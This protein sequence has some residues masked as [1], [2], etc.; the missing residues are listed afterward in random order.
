[1]TQELGIARL[2]RRDRWVVGACLALACLL[3]WAWLLT[4]ARQMSAVAGM[5]GMGNMGPAPGSWVYFAGAFTMWLLMMVAMMLPS[6]S[7]M[8]LLYARMAGRGGLPPAAVFAGVYMGLWAVFSLLAAG[9]QALLVGEGLVSAATLRIGDG[10]IAG[11]L[12]ILAGLYQLTPLK[13]ACLGACRSPFSFLT[14]LWQPGLGG[15]LRLGLRHGLYCLGC[16]W[17]LMALLFVGGVMSLPWVALL[18]VIVLIE[19]LAPI[20]ETGGKILGAL[21]ASVGLALIVDPALLTA[22]G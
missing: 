20:G 2:L 13:Q 7:P 21:A 3:A 18:A 12:L 22:G 17:A 15:A 5:E 9:A 1:M 16:C 4:T 11:A 6:A 8:I 10:R 14:R 19:K